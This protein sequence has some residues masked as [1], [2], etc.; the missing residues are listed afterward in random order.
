MSAKHIYIVSVTYTETYE[1]EA[2]SPQEA[3]DLAEAGARAPLH[4]IAKGSTATK[5]SS[6]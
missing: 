6:R 1:V 2:R 5:A 4:T 3:I